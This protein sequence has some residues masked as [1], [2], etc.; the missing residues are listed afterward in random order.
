MIPITQYLMLCTEYMSLNAKNT[1]PNTQHLIHNTQ[2]KTQYSFLNLLLITLALLI[3]S[4]ANQLPPSG[5]QDDKIPPR[6]TSVSPRPGT[7]N[8]KGNELTFKFDEYVDRRSFE[9]SFFISP[10]PKGDIEF[11]WSGREVE[12]EFTKPLDKNKTYLVIIGKDLRDV[13]GG[14]A[15]SSPLSFAFSTGSKIDKSSISGMVF[16]DNNERV[17]ILAYLKDGKPEEQLNPEKAVPDYII[18]V[19][20]DGSFELQNLPAGNYRIF[21]ITD[22]D[23]NNLYDKDIDK[24]A[25]LSDDPQ[26]ISDSSI[27]SLNFLLKNFEI[28]RNSPGFVKDFKADSIN[29]ILSGFS[30]DEKNI[31]PDYRLYLLFRNN[32]LSKSDIVNNFTL[33][34][35]AANKSY[36]LVFN[37]LN[38]SLLEVFSTERFGMSSNLKLEIDLANTSKKY[39]YVRNFKVAGNN[40]FGKVSGKI[41]SETELASPV[42]INLYSTDNKLNNY[43]LRLTD[44]TDFIFSEVLE[45]NYILFSFIDENDDGKYSPGNH[46]PFTASEKFVIY[47]KEIKVKGS[48]NVEN[49]FIEF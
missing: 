37:W 47:D 30:D 1:I 35:S 29:Y 15:L 32:D 13:R 8:F 6:I 39:S 34:D 19:S 12:V 10:K 41:V 33:T 21:A 16:S 49:V 26:L 42:Y 40:S 3:C 17:K 11:N 2:Y 28:N 48:W 43:T 44:T 46:F 4:C 27:I 9:E 20:G 38:D 45:G 23:R 14:N 7:T 22:E 18:Q 25:V 31:P 36:K 24:I 5:G